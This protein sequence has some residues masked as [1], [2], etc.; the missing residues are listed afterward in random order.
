MNPFSRELW[1]EEQRLKTTSRHAQ[2]QA[3]EAQSSL[4]RAMDRNAAAG[5]KALSKI[6]REHNLP[7][8]YGPLYQLFTVPEVYRQATEVTAGASLFHVVVDNDSTATKVLELMRREKAGRVT[9]MPLNRLKPKA[10]QY[11][12]NDNSVQP[13]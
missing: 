7:G 1:K 10:V 3:T 9:F 13:L 12:E 4:M 5:L 8:V 2:D 11:P 6:T